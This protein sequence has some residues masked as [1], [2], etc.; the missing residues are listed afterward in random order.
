MTPANAQDRAQ[1]AQLTAQV[2]DVMGDAVAAALVEQGYTGEQPAQNAVARGI[3]LEVV[4]L[5]EAKKGCGLLPRRWVVERSVGWTA[6]LRSNS[7]Y[8]G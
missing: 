5:P 6:R 7:R 1:F 8:R 4:Q 2:Q 3:P